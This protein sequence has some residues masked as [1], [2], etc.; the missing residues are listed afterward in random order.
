MEIVI[1][2]LSLNGIPVEKP[3]DEK[4]IYFFGDPQGTWYP[5][6]GN[7]LSEID[8]AGVRLHDGLAGREFGN[9]ESY[10]KILAYI[11]EVLTMAGLNSD[12]LT[13]SSTPTSR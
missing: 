10:Y 8:I 12:P 11:P 9:I 7:C 3:L 1:Q 13:Q 5:T 4:I 2:Y 6:D